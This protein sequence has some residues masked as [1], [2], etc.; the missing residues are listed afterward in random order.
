M[1]KIEPDLKPDFYL[2][3]NNK[4]INKDREIKIK[5]KI[6]GRKT[7]VDSQNY[8]INV[9]EKIFDV[10]YSSYSNGFRYTE[11][12]EKSTDTYVFL[13]CS[14]TFGDGL[15]DDETLPYYF[16][17][18]YDFEKNVLNCGQKG[19]SS[20]TALNILNNKIFLLFMDEKSKIKH[21]F[22]SLMQDHI[23]RNFRVLCNEPSD[24]YILKDKK[25]VIT[26][27][28]V[29]FKCLFARSYIF[30]KVF[31]PVIDEKFRQ[32][33]EDYL[34]N[35]LEEINKIIEEKYN[36]KFTIIVWPEYY[37]DTFIDK[38]KET[39][40]DLIFLPEYFDSE[41]DYRIKYDLHPTAKANKEIAEILYNH[42]NKVDTINKEK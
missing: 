42:I 24:C 36:S 1:E 16:S 30:R 35:S 34:I 31:L 9:Y 28:L 12:N 40:L 7:L 32:Y 15:N 13:G 19:H 27:T 4:Q 23:Y 2:D 21:C 20:N 38:L 22:Y 37:G 14:F 39:N 41:E 25:Y 6:D 5:S 17:E 11:G 18:L 8:D 26:N 3:L 33:Y 10:Y 29:K